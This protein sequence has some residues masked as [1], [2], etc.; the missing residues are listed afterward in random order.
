MQT[1]TILQE[2]PAP[3]VVAMGNVAYYKF[4]EVSA[5]K[6]ELIFVFPFL[7][8]DLALPFGRTAY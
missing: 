1:K 2:L 7:S 5:A 6:N 4:Q 8:Y 3:S